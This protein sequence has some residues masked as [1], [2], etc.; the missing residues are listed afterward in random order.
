VAIKGGEFELLLEELRALYGDGD[1]PSDTGAA[2]AKIAAAAN[3]GAVAKSFTVKLADGTEMRAI[4]GA[5]M[6]KSLTARVENNEGAITKALGQLLDIVKVQ[7]ARIDKLARRRQGSAETGTVTTT[8]FFAKALAGQAAGNVSGHDV[9]LAEACLNKGQPVPPEI[10]R[11]V[12]G[13]GTPRAMAGSMSKD[14]FFGKALQA[15]AAGRVSGHEI[16]LAEVAI[17]NGR[18]PD[19]NLVRRLAFGHSGTRA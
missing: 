10:V 7:A 11:K 15:Q 14:E 17:N 19:P 16:A 12:M 9:A 8:E 6:V 18:Q 1:D 2:D 3:D 4:D 13:D 5:D